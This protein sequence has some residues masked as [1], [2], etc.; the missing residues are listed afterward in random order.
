MYLEQCIYD[1]ILKS[2]IYIDND[3]KNIKYSDN[4]LN[5]TYKIIIKKM[6]LTLFF[7]LQICNTMIIS[8]IFNQ[9]NI[10]KNY[11]YL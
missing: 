6:L 9:V 11:R 2:V 4:I 1:N 7:F 5:K 8:N 3:R 10:Y